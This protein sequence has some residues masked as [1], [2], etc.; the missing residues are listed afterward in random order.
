[1]RALI[2]RLW[3]VL[4]LAAWPASTAEQAAYIIE[5]VAGTDFVGDGGP[6]VAAQLC[7]AE[8]VAVDGQGNLYIADAADHRVRKVTPS[9]EI[10]TVAGNGHPGF[11]GDGGPAAAALLASPYGVAVDRYGNLYIAEVGYDS[12]GL[13]GRVRRVSPDGVIRTIAGGGLL[14]AD[15]AGDAT[16]ARLAGPRNV[17]VDLK[18]N[19]YISEYEGHRVYKVGAD[20]V[21][22]VVAGTGVPGDSKEDVP[23]VRAQ[24]R[25]PKGLAVDAA[26]NLF[27]VDSGNHAIR[28]VANG[29][30]STVVRGGFEGTAASIL[31]NPSGI[32]ADAAGN[33]YI[34]DTGNSRILRLA[35]QNSSL[36]VVANRDSQ[37][38]AGSQM[39]SSW[40]DVAVGIE[41]ALYIA[42]GQ[43]V[44]RYA[45]S[46]I[47]TVAGDGAYHFR[48]NGAAAVMTRLY[49]PYGL[50]LDAAG[51]LYIADQGNDRIR[52]VTPSGIMTT[53]AGPGDGRSSGDGGLAVS[54]SVHQPAGVAPDEAGNLW[55]AE[56][57]M[58]RIRR[59]GRDGII[60]T[61]AGT[62]LPGFS[63]DAGNQ[64]NSPTGVVA[65]GFGNLYFSDTLNHRVRKLDA[66]G[67]LST[68]AGKGVRGYAGDG[69]LA[70]E[71]QLDTPRF[72][73]LDAAGNLYIA[74]QGNH[75]IRKVTN[76]YPRR[77]YTVAGTGLPG[78][79][80][81]GEAAVKARLNAPAGVAV[82][83]D[84]NLFIADSGNHRTRM[85]STGGIL[86]TIAGTGAAGF[87]GDGGLA[88]AA[89]L[90]TPTGLALDGEG[91]LYV[92][93]NENNHVRRLKPVSAGAAAP[94]TVAAA[95]VVNG[96]SFQ[97][98]PLAPGEIITIFGSGLGPEAPLSADLDGNGLLP[99]SL[100]GVQVL[101]DGWPA[102]LFYV[103]SRQINL[104]APYYLAGQAVT[105][106][107]VQYLGAAV[108]R[109]TVPVADSAPA[110]FTLGPATGQVLALNEDGTLNSAL[111]PAARGSV[112]VLYATGEGQTNPAGVNGKPA[113]PPYPQPLAPVA[114][115]IGGYK[116][117]ILY[118]GAAPGYAG[119]MQINARV[120]AGY[121]GSGILPVRLTVGGVSSQSGVTLAV[122]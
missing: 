34:A 95:S 75:C 100:G 26:G 84:G 52:K 71:A 60:S 69:G 14:V 23:A 80:G 27:I 7:S 6:A 110:L 37:L 15:S 66:N 3:L 105:Q 90:H 122:K 120:P 64:L 50:A 29:I 40:R 68:V 113:A 77:I 13:K 79:S 83:K 33:L 30:M 58:H 38:A 36:A 98:G 28:K 81:D 21:I 65:D 114:L 121:A 99:K 111:N 87:S 116:A 93:D 112:V 82:D 62:G 19:V 57:A 74:D 25:S 119:L 8:G 59:I 45:S 55:I 70:A 92:A 44:A 39:P 47:E 48:A 32:A 9:G 17:A 41:S 2:A 107:E 72:L 5:T 118:A 108:A 101:F 1:M 91:N 115:Q 18:G 46:Q 97:P 10:T 54:A 43:R 4:W 102:A 89:Q 96:A 94:V 51:N 22:T 12:L 104:Q 86:T 106:I 35:A 49:G 88:A 42:A 73:A 20:G 31:N 67:N 16:A 78:F 85:V 24:L 109:A 11:A 103:S 61:A 76:S 117:E 53:I 56:F 63:G